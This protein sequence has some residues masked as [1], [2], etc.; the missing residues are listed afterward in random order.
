[1]IYRRFN[2][3]QKR[4][5]HGISAAIIR[6]DEG[7]DKAPVVVAQGTGTLANNIIKLAKEHD[8]P[9]QEDT[10]LI[11]NLIDMDLGD[12]VPPQLYSVMAEILLMLEEM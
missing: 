6:Y 9:L 5:L 12:S 2:Q 11:G 8:I 7:Y 1:M 10:Q 4:A 3:K